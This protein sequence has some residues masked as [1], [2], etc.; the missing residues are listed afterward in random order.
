MSTRSDPVIMVPPERPFEIEDD[1]SPRDRRHAF[2][3]SLPFPEATFAYPI[4]LID[5]SFSGIGFLARRED[6]PLLSDALVLIHVNST[7]SLRA[8]VQR[9]ELGAP[10]K[11][12]VRVGA[13]FIDLADEDRASLSALVTTRWG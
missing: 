1:A 13:R 5:I 9:V 12:W 3:V 8:R 4:Q 6:A 11:K 2:R 7:T 10:S